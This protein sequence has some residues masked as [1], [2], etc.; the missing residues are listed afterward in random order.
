MSEPTSKMRLY[1]ALPGYDTAAPPG[2]TLRVEPELGVG[3]IHIFGPEPERRAAPL[4]ATAFP[5]PQ[6]QTMAGAVAVAW[7]APGEWLLTGPEPHVA[8]LIERMD[9]RGGDGILATDLTH[10][11][12]SFLIS[13]TGARD[14]L[15]AHCPLDLW[16]DAFP[17]HAVAR[18]LLG[19]ASMFLAR[20]PDAADGPQFRIIIDQTMGD[21]AVRML[22]GAPRRQGV[23]E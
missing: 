19:D 9:A 6:R 14:A 3:K 22:A 17:V 5:P 10:A 18:S 2:L 15:A 4:A 16:P 23:L 20:L 21:Y 11:R 7:L 1:R 8:A 12:V 13:G